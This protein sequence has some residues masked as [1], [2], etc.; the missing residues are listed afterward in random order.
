MWRAEARV[1]LMNLLYARG[2]TDDAKDQHMR[3]GVDLLN[4]CPN[5]DALP[6]EG[7]QTNLRS[8]ATTYLLWSQKLGTISMGTIKERCRAII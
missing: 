1:S 8:A 2:R 7:M 6:H 4:A 5:M 3:L